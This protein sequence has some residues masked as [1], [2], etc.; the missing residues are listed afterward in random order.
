MLVILNCHEVHS[1]LEGCLLGIPTPGTENDDFG[2]PADD[3]VAE[4]KITTL[5]LDRI[6]LAA[7][8][9]VRADLSFLPNRPLVNKDT[10]LHRTEDQQWVVTGHA[11][12]QFFPADQVDAAILTWLA[13][14]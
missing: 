11:R 7:L 8:Q 10:T 6:L 12:R 13:W 2:D 3:L 4:S 14:A 9:L 5:P 1:H